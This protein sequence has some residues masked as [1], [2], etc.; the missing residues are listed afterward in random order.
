MNTFNCNDSFLVGRIRSC[1]G[2]FS[3]LMF[4]WILS[5]SRILNLLLVRNHQAE[6]ITVKASYSITQQRN[7]DAGCTQI[8]VS[9]SLPSRPRCRLLIC[10]EYYLH[11]ISFFC[12][13]YLVSVYQ[14]QT[15]SHGGHIEAVPPQMTACAP[16]TKIVPPPSEDCAPKK[17][18]GS[19]LLECKSRP[20]LVDCMTFL[21]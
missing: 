19:R 20:K 14:R 21:E 8:M 5:N 2:V 18:T 10:N 9:G 16:Q 6:K 1:L 7:Q 13:W 17:L 4:L 12:W 11:K 15:R 3:D